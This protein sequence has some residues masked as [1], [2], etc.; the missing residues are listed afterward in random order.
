MKLGYQRTINN[1][2]KGAKRELKKGQTNKTMKAMN[3]LKTER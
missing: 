1:R 2:K 3:K